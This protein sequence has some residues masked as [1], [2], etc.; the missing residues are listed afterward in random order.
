MEKN[1]SNNDFLNE[2]LGK[3]D[4]IRYKLWYLVYKTG[5]KL[6]LFFLDQWIEDGPLGQHFVVQPRWRWQKRITSEQVNWTRS[7]D[8]GT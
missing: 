1:S 4:L 7:D 8:A 6:N 5:T 2:K 3:I